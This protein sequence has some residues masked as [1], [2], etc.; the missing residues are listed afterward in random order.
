MLIVHK[1]ILIVNYKY[2]RVYHK[3]LNRKNSYGLKE[4]VVK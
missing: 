4:T 2:I 3:A 1:K